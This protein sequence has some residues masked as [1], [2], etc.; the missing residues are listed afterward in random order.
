L[1]KHALVIGGTGMLRETTLWLE[2]QGYHV[3]VVAR[4]QTKL[5]RIK[6]QAVDPENVSTYAVDYH[7]EG[8]FSD[9]I[10][11]VL[12]GNG[13]VDL[14]VV[15]IHS[16]APKAFPVLVQNFASKQ[17]S[18]WALYH[19]NGSTKEIPTAIPELPKQCSYHRIYLGF[20]IEMGWSR[21]LS[22]HEISNGVILAID[23]NKPLHIVGTLKPWE[24]RP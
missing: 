3:S 16:S 23:R 10:N 5:N 2:K 11:R 15:W 22:N 18:N 6:E 12:D 24:M 19:V 7:D 13:A 4:T 9:T 14:V 8:E 20:V 17:D 1:K 21:W